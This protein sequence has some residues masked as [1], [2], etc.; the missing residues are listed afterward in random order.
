[1]SYKN[2]EKRRE[3]KQKYRE[4][5]QGL[6]NANRRKSRLKRVY[7][8]E[9]GEYERMYTAQG[10][11]C[12]ICHQPETAMQNGVLRLLSVDHC[13]DTGK[14]RGLL[15]HHCNA[16]LGHFRDNADIMQAAMD[17]LKMSKE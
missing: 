13:H 7:G 10:G 11:V 15:C 8:L 1:M 12:A 17:Y 9:Y 6:V 4:N 14:V 2:P 16:G 5:N 3:A